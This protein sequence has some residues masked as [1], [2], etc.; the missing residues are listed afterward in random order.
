[1][2]VFLYLFTKKSSPVALI[3]QT[4][5]PF[6][7]WMYLFL[8]QLPVLF[9]FFFSSLTSDV[10]AIKLLL[11]VP[12]IFCC[13]FHFCKCLK[14]PCLIRRFYAMLSPSL[15]YTRTH[16]HKHTTTPSASESTYSTF[17]PIRQK[18][19][20]EAR[21]SRGPCREVAFHVGPADQAPPDRGHQKGK[22]HLNEFELK[23]IFLIC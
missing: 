17:R 16:T 9:D 18:T 20:Q 10:K 13:Q 3:L 5:K 21:I 1:M 19:Q 22:P 8:K 7:V 12:T 11:Y 2:L 6:L 4:N 14:L 23:T 15:C